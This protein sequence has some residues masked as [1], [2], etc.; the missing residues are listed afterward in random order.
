MFDSYLLFEKS[1]I[2]MRF[3]LFKLSLF[4]LRLPSRDENILREDIN[5]L[6]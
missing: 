1:L 2:Y 5:C 6:K 3:H 4:Y